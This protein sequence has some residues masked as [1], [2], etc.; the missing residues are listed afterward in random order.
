MMIPAGQLIHWRKQ[1]VGPE[2]TNEI[3]KIYPGIKSATEYYNRPNYY[4]APRE[5][6]VG[7]TLEY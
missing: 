7:L 1:K 4:S 3:S 5:V 6:R 2:A